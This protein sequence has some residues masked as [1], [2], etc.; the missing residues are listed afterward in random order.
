MIALK[1]EYCKNNGLILLR[2]D[3]EK[4]REREEYKEILEKFFQSFLCNNK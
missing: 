4:F 3:Y 1:I 2:I